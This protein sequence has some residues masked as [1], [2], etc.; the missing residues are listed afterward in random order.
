[1]VWFVFQIFCLVLIVIEIA[2]REHVPEERLSV[3][4]FIT[5]TLS[6]LLNL[7]F[8]WVVWAFMKQL[9]ETST[10]VSPY[11]HLKPRV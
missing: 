1:M 10:A 2:L 7:Y 4:F 3:T 6:I 9:K 8:L 5:D 11:A